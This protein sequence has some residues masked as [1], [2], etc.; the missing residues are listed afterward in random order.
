MNRLGLVI[1]AYNVAPA[2][3][4][5]LEQISDQLTDG[6]Q[7]VVVDDGSADNTL[8][9]A[10]QF[11][12]DSIKSCIRIMEVWVQL[13]TEAL[14]SAMLNTSGLSMPMMELCLVP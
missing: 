13:V 8:A 7:V 12:S 11:E 2:L 14:K 1:P 5:L 10:R 3:R 4:G 6:V 9:V